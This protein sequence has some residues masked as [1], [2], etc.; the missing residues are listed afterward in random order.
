V[1]KREGSIE[2]RAL[3]TIRERE[4]VVGVVAKCRQ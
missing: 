3:G 1:I 4:G 2:S